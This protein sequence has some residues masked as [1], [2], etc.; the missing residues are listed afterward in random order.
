MPVVLSGALD[1]DVPVDGS[2]YRA[3]VK[4][5]R[6]VGTLAV[7]ETPRLQISGATLKDRRVKVKDSTAIRNKV[8]LRNREKD[9]EYRRDAPEV[10]DVEGAA[11][12]L[13]VST[14]TLCD[15]LVRLSIPHR[16]IG[17]T[18]IFARSSLVRWVEDWTD[19]SS[20]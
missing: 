7:D 2:R 14:E 6:P 11:R 9:E 3:L 12:F 17:R 13:G 10:L 19:D 16:T 4:S 18:K 5:S 1:R 20:C 15:N 8:S